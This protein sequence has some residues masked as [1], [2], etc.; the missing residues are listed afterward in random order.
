ME[1]KTG[2]DFY[3][4]IISESYKYL[5]LNGY[6]CLEIGYNQKADVIKLIQD[7]GKYHNEYTKKDLGG[8]NRIVICQNNV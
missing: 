7:S 1:E 5:K 8:N 4:K 6:L 2:L 3:K